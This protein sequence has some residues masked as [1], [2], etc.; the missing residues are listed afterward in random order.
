MISQPFIN[1]IEKKYFG[2]FKRTPKEVGD[3]RQEFYAIEIQLLEL[4][5]LLNL[6]NEKSESF[7]NQQCYEILKMYDSAIQK[8]TKFST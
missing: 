6:P 5:K 3:L 4:F 2:T 7:V 1:L 8:L